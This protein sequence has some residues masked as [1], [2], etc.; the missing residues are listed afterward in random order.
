MKHEIRVPLL[1]AVFALVV[2]GISP[3]SALAQDGTIDACVHSSSGVLYLSQDRGNAGEECADRDEQLSWNEQGPEGPE[4]PQGPP[5]ILGTDIVEATSEIIDL[6]AGTVKFKPVTA[7]CPS[8]ST[9][10]GGG[11]SRDASGPGGVLTARPGESL[12]I[13]RPTSGPDGWFVFYRL[14]NTDGLND[15]TVTV[16]AY[17]ICA[18]LSS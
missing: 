8:G 4:G 5:G 3:E 18:E 14:D 6:P 10:L 7:E 13:S 1:G 9:V 16:A 15:A 17:A 11:G 2:L 12:V